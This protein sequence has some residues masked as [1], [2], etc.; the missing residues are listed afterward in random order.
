MLNQIAWA[1]VLSA[2]FMVCAVARI[3]TRGGNQEAG[4]YALLAIACAILALRDR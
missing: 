3:V 2:A 4:V 1:A